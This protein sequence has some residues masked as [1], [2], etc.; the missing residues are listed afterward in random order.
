MC[1]CLSHAPTGDLTCDPGMCSDWESNQQPFGSHVGTQS[2]EPHQPGLSLTFSE[3]ET[4][5]QK[6]EL[7]QSHKEGE[8][9]AEQLQ[10][11]AERTPTALPRFAGHPG[12]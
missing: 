7:A 12:L 9:V 1:G 4:E 5:A 11:G 10:T 3:E 2:T 8:E 6:N